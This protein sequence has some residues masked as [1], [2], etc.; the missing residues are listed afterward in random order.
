MKS[1][2][3]ST[4]FCLFAHAAAL[5]AADEN[6][7][8]PGPVIGPATSAKRAVEGRHADHILSNGVLAATF[9]LGQDRFSLVSLEDRLHHETLAWTDPH[10]FTLR[11]K[12]GSLT[13]SSMRLAEPPELIDL[14]AATD[15]VNLASKAPGKSITAAFVDDA[16]GITVRWSAILRDGSNYLRQEISVTSAKPLEVDDIEMIDSALPGAKVIGYTDG[17][18][19][20]CGNWFLGLEHPMAKNAAHDTTGWTPMEMEA[21]QIELPITGLKPGPCTV[22]FAHRSGNHGITIVKVALV[23]EGK[24]IAEDVHPG[25]SGHQSRQNEY[26]LQIPAGAAGGSLLATLANEAGQYDGHGDITTSNGTLAAGHVTSSLPRRFTLTPGM[27]WV[28]SSATGIAPAGQLRRAFAY[29]LQRERAHPYRQYWHY[30]SWYDLNINRNDLDDPLKRMNEAQCLEVIGA[31]DKN[32]YRKHKVGLNGF[33][34]DDGWDDWNTLWGFHKGFPDG[35]SKL[36]DA[37][38]AQGAKMG[39]WLSPWGGY[40]RSHEMR[41]AFGKSHGYETNGSG[42]SLGGGKYRAVFR[43]TC[44]RMIH[45]YQQDYFK[46]DGIGTGAWATGAPPSISADLDGLVGV[47]QDLRRANPHVFINC[48][49]GTWASPYWTFFADSIW[50]QGEDTAFAGKGNPRER[51]INYKDGIVHRRFAST[52]PLF[53]LNSLMYHGLVLGSVANPGQMPTPARDIES[54]RHELR[55]MV[56]YGSGLEELY[57]TPSLM[58]DEAWAV[59]AECIRFSRAN[60]RLLADSHW[61]G[62]NPEKHEIYGCAAW[63]PADGG[64]ITL[65]NP[66]DK[67]QTITLDLAKIWELPATVSGAVELRSPWPSERAKPGL[68]TPVREPL[69]ITLQPFEV[70]TLLTPRPPDS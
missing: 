53:P 47:T 51:W 35:F 49:V 43:D 12:G 61:I 23:A 37:A 34:W 44:L 63:N 22:R 25:F 68:R 46:F 5:H 52:S 60:Q 15:R 10:L 38:R 45:D 42:L 41:V 40:G 28:L 30:N 32:L 13:S 17:A 27:T 16:T 29:Y 33:V 58:T 18:P 3:R 31:F 7:Y 48:T 4:L 54:F 21:N 24:V 19:I 20:V 26:T 70:V 65:R 67:P 59:L 9:R 6:F 50:R 64:I 62:G 56:G 57:V 39:A 8:W 2:L 66:D 36:N 69:G 14:N 55:M 1:P 11:L